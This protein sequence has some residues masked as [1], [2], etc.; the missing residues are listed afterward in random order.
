MIALYLELQAG[1]DGDTRTKTDGRWRGSQVGSPIKHLPHVDLTRKSTREGIVQ[2]A[3]RVRVLAYGV[4]RSS[5][6]TMRSWEGSMIKSK[7]LISRKMD[8]LFSRT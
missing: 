5:R 2:E 7:I 8:Q 3:L 4:F 1:E 6:V